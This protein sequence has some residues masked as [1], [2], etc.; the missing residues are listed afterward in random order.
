MRKK[1]RMSQNN[2]PNDSERDPWPGIVLFF[3]LA[4]IYLFLTLPGCGAGG[5]WTFVL[6]GPSVISRNHTRAR[7]IPVDSATCPVEFRPWNAS[8]DNR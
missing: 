1:N 2:E 8:C 4:V 7:S 6:G 5:D 3:Y